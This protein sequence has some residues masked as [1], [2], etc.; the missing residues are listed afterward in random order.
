[1]LGDGGR[2]PPSEVIE[3]DTNGSVAKLN[4][5]DPETDGLDFYESLEGMRVQVNDAVAVSG[6]SQYKE[7]A[8]VGG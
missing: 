4:T 1:M 8:V 3:D 6:T 7:I 5:F 2:I